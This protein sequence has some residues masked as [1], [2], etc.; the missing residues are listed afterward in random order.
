MIRPLTRTRT[1]SVSSLELDALE[2]LP[3]GCVASLQ[4]ARP[5]PLSI[6]TIEAKGPHCLT[7]EHAIGKVLQLGELPDDPEDEDDE[8]EDE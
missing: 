3:C 4:H 6:V 2:S 7:V 8:D 5:W 1:L